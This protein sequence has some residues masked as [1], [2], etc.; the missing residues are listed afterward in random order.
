[1]SQSPSEGTNE[2]NGRGLS[3]T[4]V[5]VR[6]G[7]PQMNL[8]KHARWLVVFT[9]LTVGGGLTLLTGSPIPLWHIEKL[10]NPIAVK[11][12]TETHMMLEDGQKITLPFISEIPH[13][14]PL[15]QASITEGIEINEDGSAFGLMWL[16]RSCGNDPVV[17]YKV[18]VN[19]GDL[20]GALQPQGI[21]ESIVHPDAIAWL[22]EHKRIDLTQPSRSHQKGHLTMWDRINMSAVRKQFE[23]S[24][25]L[26]EADSL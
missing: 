6:S 3:I 5:A 20:A 19:L 17:W 9:V 26:A 18:R 16:D 7:D 4:F 23:H 14:N 11:S 2:Y 21:D 25:R 15:F 10:D 8:S 22:E 13:D 1:V 12:V 24:A